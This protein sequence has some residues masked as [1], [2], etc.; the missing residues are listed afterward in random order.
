ML[1][2]I[3]E[4][5]SFNRHKNMAYF[6]RDDGGEGEEIENLGTKSLP[7]FS[8]IMVFYIDPLSMRWSSC[9]PSL[10]SSPLETTGCMKNAAFQAGFTC[11]D[12]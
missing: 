3:K 2:L 11:V 10:A 8:G 9:S 5:S 12:R 1:P 7:N 4:I 6:C